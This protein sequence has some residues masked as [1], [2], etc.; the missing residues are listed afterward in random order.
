MGVLNLSPDSFTES[1]RFD[2]SVL[3]SGADI[4][5]IGAV[6]SR[7]GADEVSPEQEWSRLEP[8][9][10]AVAGSGL[11]FSVDTTRA[12]IARRAYEV[13]GHFTVNDIRAGEDDPEML[14]TVAQLGLG[15]VAMHSRGNPRTMDGLCDY[16]DGGVVCELVRY[17][18]GFAARAAACGLTDWIIDPGLGFA[19]T[20]AQCMEVLENLERLSA[21]GHPVLVG[22]ADKRFTAGDTE[23]IH[24]LA[25]RHG[26]DILRVHDVAACR[27]TVEDFLNGR[28]PSR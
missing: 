9:L 8:V 28:R 11:E 7:P 18:T 22:A 4:V 10:K 21:L 27:R 12:V 14:P 17:F 3:R 25:L 19:K 23:N 15:Y 6:S 1:S 13:L 2:F 26:V 16:P 20:P 5:D 24:R